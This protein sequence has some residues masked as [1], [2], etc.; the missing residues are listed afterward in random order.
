MKDGFKELADT[1]R[2]IAPRNDAA[3]AVLSDLILNCNAVAQPDLNPAT[4]QKEIAAIRF[5]TSVFILLLVS[6]PDQSPGG[7]SLPAS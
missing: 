1:F 3:K 4:R 5:D 6:A 7:S 2:G